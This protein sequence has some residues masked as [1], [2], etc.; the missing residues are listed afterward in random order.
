MSVDG[1]VLLSQEVKE[2][3]QR[4]M[5]L[6]VLVPDSI[7][8]LDTMRIDIMI[9]LLADTEVILALIF[10]VSSSCTWLQYLETDPT[11]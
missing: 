1:L 5:E 10:T 4:I 9:A 8:R 11:P 7:A 6:V 2:V 3:E